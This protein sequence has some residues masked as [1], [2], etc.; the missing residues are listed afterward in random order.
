MRKILLALLFLALPAVASAQFV[1][2]KSA[3]F[4]YFTYSD[5]TTHGWA[6]PT[7]TSASQLAMFGGFYGTQSFGKV[8]FVNGGT[9]PAANDPNYPTHY[10]E[11]SIPKGA[12]GNSALVITAI[13]ALIGAPTGNTVRVYMTPPGT[14]GNSTGGGY[15]IWSVGGGAGLHEMGH[16]L[17]G[18]EHSHAQ[19]DTG[20]YYTDYGDRFCIM[21]QGDGVSAARKMAWF[22]ATHQIV[23]VLTSQTVTLD[24]AFNTGPGLKAVR[25]RVPLHSVVGGPV[26]G[27]DDYVLE[28]RSAYPG[29]VPVR[30]G[31]SMLTLSPGARIG[32]SQPGETWTIQAGSNPSVPLTLTRGATIGG[33]SGNS[34]SVPV[35]ITIGTTGPP[36]TPPADRCMGLVGQ[37]QPVTFDSVPFL[38]TVT[39]S[40]CVGTLV[41][42]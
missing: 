18:Y 41:V 10:Y 23:D 5:L 20:G 4:I 26:T 1:G 8:A 22:D 25:V 13:N 14:P 11:L 36:T 30:K 7:A 31:L 6:D 12:S 42:Q 9:F 21:G 39:S 3:Q 24:S 17:I 2:T 29:W 37:T 19:A 40:L 27:Y 15:V 34:G 35:T 16:V 32:L 33:W 38:A 28:Y